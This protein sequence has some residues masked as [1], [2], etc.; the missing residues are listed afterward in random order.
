MTS[1][2]FTYPAAEPRPVSNTIGGVTFQDP[3]QWLE[4][5]IEEVLAWQAAQNELARAYIRSTPGWDR[6]RSTVERF[7]ANAFWHWAPERFGD[8]WFRQR[9]PD[10]A[11]LPILEVSGSPTGPGRT[12]VDL[13]AIADERVAMLMFWKP[14][15]DGRRLAYGVS[16]HAA[17]TA[18]KVIDVD[19]GH[20]LVDG[21]PHAGFYSIAWLPDSTG[22]Y[23]VVWNMRR[24]D[25]GAAQSSEILLK[26]VEVDASPEPQQLQFDDPASH[27]TVSPDGR[28]AMVYGA[29]LRPHYIKDLAADGDWQPFL[30]DVP[31]TFRGAVMG[32]VFLAVTDDGAPNGRVV[33]IPL[34]T[35]TDRS[36]WTELLP[37]G[38]AVVFAITPVGQRLVL[39]E[40]AEGASRLRVLQPEGT[41]EGEIPLPGQGMVW[42]GPGRA[43]GLVAPGS[44]E[45]TFVFSSL[46]RSPASYR[47]DLNTL[48][49]ET[50]TEPK[51]S[52]EDAIVRNWTARSKDGARIPYKVV[53]RA[54]VDLTVPQPTIISG[55]GGL[56][57]A[58]LPS[59]LFTLPAVWVQLGGVYVHAH[60]RGGGEFGAE[61][62]QAARR[63]TKQKTFDD[64]YA[65][66][67]DMIARGQT[68][69]ELLGIFGTSV[70]SLPAAVAVTQRP[71]LFRASI[72]M[73]P[74]LDLL[75]CRQDPMT[76]AD[77]VGSDYGNPDDPNDAPI[78]YAYSPYHHVQ[79]GVPYPAVL[80]D[81]GALNQ[82]CP[83]WHG[84]KM[85][86]R[87]QHAT[88]SGRPILLRV[89]D[90][91]HH[92]Q[93]TPAQM[94]DREIEELAFF[95]KELG[96][97]A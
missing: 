42:V 57:I 66:A 61:W 80:I 5:D 62:W 85:A 10:G 21:L 34:A 32:D 68:S 87:L 2:E 19:S 47:C 30:R 1:G 69:P 35:P 18:V 97:D 72:P 22:F 82:T 59:Y 55:Y 3:F 75:R 94:M 16:D 79:N 86:A 15:R 24:V 40:H 33:S 48:N 67:E 96:L 95:V 31:G 11:R 6:L 89:R 74:I 76:M 93:M 9:L 91:G 92:P 71:G 20:V 88:S 46:T 54:D 70:G 83:A 90:V 27:P 7:Y 56:N 36:T 63:Q 37:A 84:R 29:G 51:A 53:A 65:V 64:L 39:G 49:V 38:D 45:C 50:L 25:G 8:R 17:V 81:C 13:N 78:L 28:Y 43:E 14:S 26:R 23:Y 73:L 12:L 41:V 52:V 58:W 77:I 60:L 4:Q 44:D